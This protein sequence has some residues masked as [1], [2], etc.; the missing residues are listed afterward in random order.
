MLRLGTF[1][2]DCTPPV[3]WGVG[4]GITGTT[5]GVRDPLLLRGFVLDDKDQRCLIATMDFCG[6]MNSAYD[7]LVRV[8]A[9]A[10]HAPEERVIIHCIHQH[11]AP[12]LNY[13]VETYLNG[14]TY[15]RQ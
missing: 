12:L 6:L 1:T 13:E 11:D 15:P 8:L 4:F 9:K 3:G 5:T 10:V 2:V 14:E 7:D